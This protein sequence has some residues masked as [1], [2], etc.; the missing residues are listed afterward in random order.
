V[1][2]DGNELGESNASPQLLKARSDNQSDGVCQSFLRRLLSQ[3]HSR[4][5]VAEEYLARSYRSLS[6]RDVTALGPTAILLNALAWLN[7]DHVAHARLCGRNRSTR[8]S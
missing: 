4:L 2:E 3:R 5:A 7:A 1:N 8:L 6:W